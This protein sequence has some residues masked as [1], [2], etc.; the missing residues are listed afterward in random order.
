MR[1][2]T[3]QQHVPFTSLESHYRLVFL[4]TCYHYGQI[5]LKHCPPWLPLPQSLQCTLLIYS[6]GSPLFQAQPSAP[7]RTH[8]P[9]C[10]SML[11]STSQPHPGHVVPFLLAIYIHDASWLLQHPLN[12]SHSCDSTHSSTITL[13]NSPTVYAVTHQG[14]TWYHSATVTLCAGKTR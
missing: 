9:P 4:Q 14:P 7:S 1:K 6:L 13:L 3:P 11:A 12:S 10:R 2:L 8:S 5:F